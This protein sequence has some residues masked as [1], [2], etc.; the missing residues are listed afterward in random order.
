MGEVGDAD[1][2]G[3]GLVDVPVGVGSG[4]ADDDVSDGVGSTVM[5]G[6]RSGPSSGE[7]AMATI[8]AT[9]A[10]A[11]TTPAATIVTMDFMD[12]MMG[13]PGWTAVRAR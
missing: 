13:T 4:E 10:P 9:A 1:E 6:P 5:G 8:P 7:D 2:L 3:V 11:N 12:T